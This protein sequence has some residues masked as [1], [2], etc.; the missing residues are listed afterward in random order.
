MCLTNVDTKI[1]KHKHGYKVY[2]YDLKTKTFSPYYGYGAEHSYKLGVTY[3]AKVCSGEREIPLIA[4]TRGQ[5]Y[6]AGFHYH[7]KLSDA[8]KTS[9][10]I[11]GLNVI[12]RVQISNIL[13]TGLD[14][15]GL[16][17]VSEFITPERI[18]SKIPVPATDARDKKHARWLKMS[19]SKKFI[20]L[21][22]K[23]EDRSSIT[24]DIKKEFRNIVKTDR[25][26]LNLVILIDAAER[27]SEFFKR[28]TTL[29]ISV[30]SEDKFRKHY[31]TIVGYKE[32][33]PEKN[34]LQEMSEYSTN[35][36]YLLQ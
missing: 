27:Q 19:V 29:W 11:R 22:K 13:A 16:C 35:M 17:G 5:E 26:M 25:D 34:L 23:F 4:S 31:R 12:V 18:M 6:R 28:S 30:L 21:I 32:G 14:H 10:G 8:R 36:D 20:N 2:K 3:S 7:L 1:R 9:K 15:D 33:T 24:E